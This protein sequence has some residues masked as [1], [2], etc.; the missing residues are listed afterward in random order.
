VDG[1]A[2]DRELELLEWT[3]RLH[4]MCMV[5]DLKQ[6]KGGMRVRYLCSSV[7]LDLT[8]NLIIQRTLVDKRTL[9]TGGFFDCLLL[10][11]YDWLCYTVDRESIYQNFVN[12]KDSTHASLAGAPK[13]L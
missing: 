7:R 10:H 9:R 11:P 1:L 4:S 3:W 2:G 12:Q 5:R 8:K 6:R 13:F